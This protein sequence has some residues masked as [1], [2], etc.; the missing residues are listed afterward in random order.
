METY[1]P[2][3]HDDDPVI[4]E[5]W[6]ATDYALLAGLGALCTVWLVGAITIASWVL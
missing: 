5:P 6:T 3:D 2:Y 4:E 1:V